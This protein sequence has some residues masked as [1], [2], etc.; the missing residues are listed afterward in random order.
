MSL[1]I[2]FCMGVIGV[3]TY[4]IFLSTILFNIKNTDP[5][6]FLF[7]LLMS[8]S[9][10][11]AIMNSIGRL[12]LGIDYGL[13]SRYITFTI[14]F[15][16]GIFYFLFNYLDIGWRK[17]IFSNFIIIFSLILFFSFIDSK[18]LF[19]KQFIRYN[20]ATNSVLNN[21]LTDIS[22]SNLHPSEKLR[23]HVIFYLRDHKKNIFTDK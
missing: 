17:I 9:L 1:P 14:F 5:I 21:D 2:A 8:F 4:F 10:C 13:S 12:T 7:L 19:K 15:W 23:N 16:I 6:N 11:I 3:T 18:K 22:L 20:S